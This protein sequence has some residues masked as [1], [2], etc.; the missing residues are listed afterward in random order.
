MVAYGGPKELTPKDS[1]LVT[2]ATPYVH[3]TITRKQWPEYLHGGKGVKKPLV[4]SGTKRPRSRDGTDSE[5]DDDASR[6]SDYDLS[7]APPVVM[8]SSP[9]KSRPS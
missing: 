8:E 5:S 7:D 9:R 1:N 4:P 2:L 3:T 6:Q